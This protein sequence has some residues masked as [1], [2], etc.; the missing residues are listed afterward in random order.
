VLNKL[1]L[2]MLLLF[3]SVL[4]SAY[5]QSETI[6][7]IQKH[8]ERTAFHRFLPINLNKDKTVKQAKVILERKLQNPYALSYIISYRVT[9]SISLRAS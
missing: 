5:T 8:K 4:F 6:T 7:L 2:S 3:F 9:L 1:V